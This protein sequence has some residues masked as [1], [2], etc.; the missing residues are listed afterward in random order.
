MKSQL[1]L[2]EAKRKHFKSEISNFVEIYS[3]KLLPVF[4][5]IEN[6]AEK[7]TNDIYNNSMSQPACDD[8][9]DPGSIA[10]TATEEGIEYYSYL[11]LGKYNLTATWHATLY[12]MWEQQAR[13]FLF[14]EISHTDKI[15]FEKFCDCLSKIKIKFKLYKVDIESFSCWPEI[16]EL[17]LLCNVIKHGEGESAKDL[18]KVKATLFKKEDGKNHVTIFKTTLLEETLNIDETTLN[19]YRDALLFFWDEILERNYSDEL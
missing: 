8:S 10:E 19:N 5:D 17:R 18:R 11:K 16:N 3:Q 4:K 2:P 13:L 9:M 12:Q 6:D 1:Y 14:Q 7:Y 15:E